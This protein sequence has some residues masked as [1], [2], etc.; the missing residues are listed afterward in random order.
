M[1]KGPV[2]KEACERWPNIAKIAS[3]V[4]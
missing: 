2:A 4:V 1:I 3:N